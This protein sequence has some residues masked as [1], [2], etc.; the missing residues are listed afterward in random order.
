MKPYLIDVPVSLNVFIRPNELNQV[1]SIVKKAKPSVLFLVSDGPRENIVS[2]FVNIRKSREVV[3]KVDW[4]CKV[5]RLYPDINQGMYTTYFLA[6]KFIFEHVDKCIFLEDDVLPS[7]S[8][9][10]FCA[11]LLDKYK[12]DLRISYISGM[13]YLGEYNAAN[14]DYFF[15]GEASIWGY[16]KWRRTFENESL[17]YKNDLYTLDLMREIT[18][19]EKKGYFKKI[20]GY[21]KDSMFEGHQPGPEF[22]KNLLRFLQNQLFIV[23][24]KNMIRNIGFGEA[25]THGPGDIRKIPKRLQKLYNLKTYEYD[26]PLTHPKYV[27]KDLRYEREVNRILAWNKPLAKICRRCE[28][29]VRHLLYGDFRRIKQRTL[30]L[31]KVQRNLEK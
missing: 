2:D 31:L 7:I 28:S 14:T 1:F 4:Q 24:K 16:A 9:F 17:E 26:F 27:C 23:P 21:A 15:S 5:Y 10:R 6:E 3:E 18:K 29:L 25:A 19:R 11:E 12:D 13:N 20:E 8:F 30:D 22:Y